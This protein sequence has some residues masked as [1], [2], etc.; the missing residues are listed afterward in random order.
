MSG[1]PGFTRVVY[2]LDWRYRKAPYER[3]VRDR[4]DRPPSPAPDSRAGDHRG[5]ATVGLAFSNLNPPRARIVLLGPE[6]LRRRL[7]L[8]GYQDAEITPTRRFMR[9]IRLAG[10]R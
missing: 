6:Q 8:M 2:E 10:R 5:A 4:G 3:E 7:A 1:N 9:A